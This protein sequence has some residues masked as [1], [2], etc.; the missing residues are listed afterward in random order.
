MVEVVTLITALNE[1]SVLVKNYQGYNTKISRRNDDDSVRS[2]IS[3]RLHSIK[4]IAQSG[5]D[6]SVLEKKPDLASVFENLEKIVIESEDKIRWSYPSEPS[7]IN[8]LKK[9]VKKKVEKDMVL[10]D[11][12]IITSL[13]HI[14]LRC[15]KVDSNLCGPVEELCQDLKLVSLRISDRQQ[16]I[17]SLISWR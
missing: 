14:K 8:F 12:A 5:F 10:H 17:E 15:I 7:S 13:D 4:K 6:K 9:K 1:I 16:A 2:A 11:Y 3:S